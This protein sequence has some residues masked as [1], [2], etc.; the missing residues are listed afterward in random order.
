MWYEVAHVAG[1]T[2]GLNALADGLRLPLD[3]SPSA[4][5]LAIAISDDAIYFHPRCHDVER[6]DALLS[7]PVH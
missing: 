1:I 2:H 7:L 5:V 3:F 4:R 6:R